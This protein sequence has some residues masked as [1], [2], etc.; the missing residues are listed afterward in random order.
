MPRGGHNKKSSKMKLIKG[1]DRKS[2]SRRPPEHQP[3]IQKNP[4]TWLPKWAKVFWRKYAFKLKELGL[5]TEADQPAFETLALLYSQIR[6]AQEE[7]AARGLIVEGARGGE[8]KN[9]AFTILNQARKDFRLF[10][11]EFGLTP[12]ARERLDLPEVLE[13]NTDPMKRLYHE[14]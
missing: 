1:T 13:E 7:I 3:G 5:L 8:V 9:P 14:A 12:A 2:R 4:P 11:I 6:D 10:A